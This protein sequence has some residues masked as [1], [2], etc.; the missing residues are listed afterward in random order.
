MD[1]EFW[2]I[3]SQESFHSRP[4]R[5]NKA[6]RKDKC[7]SSSPALACRP[8]D[9]DVHVLD[10]GQ[11]QRPSRSVCSEPGSDFL[12]S[13]VPGV[14]EGYWRGGSHRSGQCEQQR[15]VV[16]PHPPPRSSGHLLIPPEV[17]SR[18]IMSFKWW[19]KKT[20][21]NRRGETGTGSQNRRRGLM[22]QVERPQFFLGNP[23][24][25]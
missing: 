4:K 9:T 18:G 10:R 22:L 2:E 5:K 6:R 16:S 11:S 7:L 14:Y 12:A 21:K 8:L 15:R 24:S 23:L 13:A 1:L 19:L 20:D 3:C 17:F 25:P